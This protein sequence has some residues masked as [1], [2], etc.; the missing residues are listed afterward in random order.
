MRLADVVVVEVLIHP[1]L[2]IPK[3]GD[4]KQFFRSDRHGFNGGYTEKVAETGYCFL[5]LE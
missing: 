2:P 1:G 3:D 4:R 5:D